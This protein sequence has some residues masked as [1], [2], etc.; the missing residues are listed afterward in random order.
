M[1]T[2]R[3]PKR[4][5]ACRECRTCYPHKRA[6]MAYCEG[7]RCRGAT[8]CLNCPGPVKYTREDK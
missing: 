2:K 1:A 4:L 3:G 7:S 6:M 5:W 8:G